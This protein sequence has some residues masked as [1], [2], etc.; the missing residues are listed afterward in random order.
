MYKERDYYTEQLIAAAISRRPRPASYIPTI[1]FL[2]SGVVSW[3]PLV[4][5]ILAD[6]KSLRDLNRTRRVTYVKECQ[7]RDEGDDRTW[8]SSSLNFFQDSSPTVPLSLASIL[9]ELDPRG[10]FSRREKTTHS[11]QDQFHGERRRFLIADIAVRFPV[12]LPNFNK[13]RSTRPRRRFSS[14]SRRASRPARRQ[15]TL[16]AVNTTATTVPY[17]SRSRLPGSTV[18]RESFVPARRVSRWQPGRWRRRDAEYDARRATSTYGISSTWIA[19]DLRLPIISRAGNLTSTSCQLE[20]RGLY[21]EWRGTFRGDRSAKDKLSFCTRFLT[22][23]SLNLRQAH[24][25]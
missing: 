9:D 3:T 12:A 14:S 20:S 21:Q 22:K 4:L 1:R 19:V 17:T 18:S 13:S 15:E 25:N 8:P 23:W 6:L 16:A 11:T 2:N 10:W 24:I 7:P 5:P